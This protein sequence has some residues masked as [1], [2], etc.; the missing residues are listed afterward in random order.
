MRIIYLVLKEPALLLV[1]L[2]LHMFTG[3]VAPS[4]R[5]TTTASGR[6][7]T[8]WPTSSSSA[9]R[10]WT[11]PV[12]RTCARNGCRSC[13]STRP[14]SPT[15]SSAPR[16]VLQC[17]HQT[18]AIR[19]LSQLTKDF[20]SRL[21]S[22]RQRYKRNEFESRCYFFALTHFP[23]H[24]VSNHTKLPW[25]TNKAQ[26][27]LFWVWTPGKVASLSYFEEYTENCF[28]RSTLFIIY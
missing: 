2:W 10:W 3:S 16:W 1:F 27:G 25:L 8:R 21:W 7:P 11:Q 19:R 13:R 17:S 4:S 18:A 20:H 26:S 9:S 5:R 6:C 15:C 28:V 22:V 23:P 12:S 24:R 14:V